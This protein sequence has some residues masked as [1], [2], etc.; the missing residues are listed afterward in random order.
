MKKKSLRQNL[1][2]NGLLQ[3]FLAKHN[4]NPAS[5]YFPSKAATELADQPLVNFMD[6]SQLHAMCTWGGQAGNCLPPGLSGRAHKKIRAR[7]SFIPSSFI[8]VDTA[9]QGFSVVEPSCTLGRLE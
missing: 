8:Q 4:I 5:K 7:L 9:V 3:D 6:V 1:I 2:E